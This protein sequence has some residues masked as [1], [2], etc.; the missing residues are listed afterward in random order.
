M[1]REGAVHAAQSA[2]IQADEA[3]ALLLHAGLDALRGGE[4]R[5]EEGVAV[6]RNGQDAVVHAVPKKRWLDWV[7]VDG[8]VWR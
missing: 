7:R 5:A 1:I 3:R 2:Q 4:G 8:W 6:E